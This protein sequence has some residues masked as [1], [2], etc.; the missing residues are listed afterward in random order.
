MNTHISFRKY[1]VRLGLIGMLFIAGCSVKAPEVKITGE[2]TA[3]ENQ[4][5]GTY[6]EIEQDSW[7]IA[8]VRS[9]TPGQQVTMSDEKK[10]V[11]SAVQN[12]RFNKDDINE[13][14]RDGVVG[15][16]NSGFLEIRDYTRLNEDPEYRKRVEKIVAE[17]NNDRQ[18]ILERS[19]QVNDQIAGAGEEAVGRVYAKIY[20]DESEL[21][22]W[23]QIE[24]NSWV[25]K[26]AEK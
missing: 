6:N 4:V 19:M 15:E 20:Q 7:T 26:G 3:L 18:T 16:N 24:D 1:C 21:N 22:T 10:K 17:E 14:K 5:I 25:K 11:L 2:K 9:A 23:I 12:R 8:S 13:F